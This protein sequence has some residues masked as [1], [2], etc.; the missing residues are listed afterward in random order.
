MKVS[1]RE[2]ELQVACR[3]QGLCL[4]RLAALVGKG[5]WDP[6]VAHRGQSMVPGFQSITEKQ[7]QVILSRRHMGLCV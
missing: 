4:R 2:G 3:L 1:G 5:D 6:V 7:S